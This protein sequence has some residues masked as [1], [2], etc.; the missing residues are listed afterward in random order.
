ME[1]QADG[2]SNYGSLNK[3]NPNSL[4]ISQLTEH[5][6]RKQC[7]NQDIFDKSRSKVDFQSRSL[8]KQHLIKLPEIARHNASIIPL[9]VQKDSVVT[10]KIERKSQALSRVKLPLVS[11]H[12][13]E[14]HFRKKSTF[15]NEY[16]K[17]T[18]PLRMAVDPTNLNS[19]KTVPRLKRK[20]SKIDTEDQNVDENKETEPTIVCKWHGNEMECDHQNESSDILEVATAVEKSSTLAEKGPKKISCKEYEKM[21]L[22]KKKS[23]KTRRKEARLFDI[24]L[25]NLDPRRAMLTSSATVRGLKVVKA[26]EVIIYRFCLSNYSNVDIQS[27]TDRI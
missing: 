13:S 9:A 10:N 23:W 8:Q 5:F 6:Q 1:N 11:P 3:L 24:D 26:N 18:Q 21:M 15:R 17:D 14:S 27:K 20:M 7:L 2:K 12:K 19:S 22:Q 4:T 16:I 25:I